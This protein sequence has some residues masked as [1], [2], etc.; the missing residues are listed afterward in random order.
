VKSEDGWDCS[1]LGGDAVHAI[2]ADGGIFAFGTVPLRRLPAR[3]D[4]AGQRHQHR[5]G[6]SEL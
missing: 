1:E 6:G 5:G 3:S 4:P 2:G